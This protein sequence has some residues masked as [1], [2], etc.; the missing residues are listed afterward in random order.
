MHFRHNGIA[1]LLEILGSIINGFAIPL[2]KEHILFL[3]KALI[4]LH[5]PRAVAIYHPQLSYCISQYVEKDP[6]TIVPVINGLVR[7][8][9][10]TN[11]AKQV[12]FLNE[13]EEVLE[14]VRGDQLV[15]VQDVL[16]KL[17]AD[18]LGSAHFQVAERALYFWNS[19][20]L[21]VNVL[22][23]NKASV[24]LPYVF[25]PLSKSAAG[26]WNQAVEGLAQ[27]ILKM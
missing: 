13:L 15:Q 5:K 12:L 19:E 16:F 6:E 27:S 11:A 2:K 4:P 21:C 8:W 10:W 25:G 23:Q 22:S 26:H 9:P 14:L 18:C 20:H 17:L 7:F 24:F 1:E 3:E